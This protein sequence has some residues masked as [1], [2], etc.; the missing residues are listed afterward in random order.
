[1]IK[2]DDTFLMGHLWA[3][4]ETSLGVKGKIEQSAVNTHRPHCSKCYSHI[5]SDI[6]PFHHINDHLHLSIV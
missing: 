5:S 6:L 3:I 1:M 2:P 4:R